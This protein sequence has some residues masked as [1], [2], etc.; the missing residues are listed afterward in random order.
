MAAIDDV[1]LQFIN[2]GDKIKLYDGATADDF[3]GPNGQGAWQAWDIRGWLNRAV[4]DLLR[5]QDW[6]TYTKQQP[7]PKS[8]RWG[9][10]DQVSRQH[11]LA[12]QNNFMLRKLCEATK[13]DLKGMPGA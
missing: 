10:R 1:N 11:L 12:E 9:L 4:W 5:F 2:P 6:T 7:N 8:N 3:P 13:I